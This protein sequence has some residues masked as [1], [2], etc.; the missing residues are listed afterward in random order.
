[1]NY[2]DVFLI[3]S[4]LCLVA[5]GSEESPTIEELE[6]AQAGVEL[7]DESESSA[8]DSLPLTV[9]KA[10]KICALEMNQAFGVGTQDP[11][12]QQSCGCIVRNVGLADFTKAIQAKRKE[13]VDIDNMHITFGFLEADQDLGP[14]CLP[15]S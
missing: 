4:V 3:V 2:K 13:G 6:A 14:K 10:K 8:L 12:I 7:L 5:C 15:F 11:E 9:E 1:M